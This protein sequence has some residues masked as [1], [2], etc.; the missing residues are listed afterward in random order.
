[1]K[2]RRDEDGR[3]GSVRKHMHTTEYLKEK[4]IMKNTNSTYKS[5]TAAFLAITLAGCSST[6]SASSAA[7]SSNGVNMDLANPEKLD[8]TELVKPDL[9]LSDATGVL[10]DVLKE[11][12]L[13][14]A[15]S[16]DYPPAEWVDDNGTI[17]GH[18]M[19]IAKYIAESLG[20]DLAIETSDFS[21]TFVS[22]DTGKADIAFS[23]YGWKKDREEAYEVSIRYVADQESEESKHTLIVPAGQEGNYDSL[24]DFVGKKIMGQANS[25]QEMYV[26]DEIL[27]L[28]KDGTTQFEKVATLD[29]AILGLASGKCDAVALDNSTAENYVASSEGAFALSGVFFDLTP[30][31]DYSGNIAL[32]KKGETDMIKAVNACLE[33]AVENGYVH[34]WYLNAKAAAGIQEAE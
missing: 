33:T 21:S 25:L 30:Y 1:M 34:T 16:P 17:Y 22:V 4:K 9:D 28:D 18:E 3:R 19:M 11:G 23:G 14:V 2:V 5:I 31:G 32:A 10:A 20:V 27:S 7:S 13:T 12:V 15:T 26:T 29:Q 24:D 6:A 8:C